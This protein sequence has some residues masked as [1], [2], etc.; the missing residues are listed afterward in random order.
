MRKKCVVC[1]H[2]P[3]KHRNMDTGLIGSSLSFPATT[4]LTLS[5]S[6][7]PDIAD[8]TSFGADSA[9]FMPPVYRCAAPGC[10]QETL[11]DPNTGDHLSLY[12]DQHHFQSYTQLQHTTSVPSFT[13]RRQSLSQSLF[14]GHQQPVVSD[15]N[16]SD[17]DEDID[18]LDLDGP[19]TSAPSLSY[20]QSDSD[21]SLT[22]F[23]RVTTSQLLAA[24]SMSLPRMPDGMISPQ[25]YTKPNKSLSNAPLFPIQAWPFSTS[26]ATTPTSTTPLSM[27][28]KYIIVIL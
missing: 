21:T 6:S 5:S 19:S 11:F 26:A 28:G 3:G 27:S 2:P 18:V 4:P 22:L 23:P 17:D 14:S 9:V 8:G 7:L 16:E 24:P 13:K 12:C 20:V 1:E 10:K 15:L 25:K